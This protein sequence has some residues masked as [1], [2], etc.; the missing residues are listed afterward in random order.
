MTADNRKCTIMK[1]VILT[2]NELQLNLFYAV[3]YGLMAQ[4][5]GKNLHIIPE[6][7]ERE[8]HWKVVRYKTKE[9]SGVAGEPVFYYQINKGA[10]Q[11]NDVRLG[12]TVSYL[13][14]EA[15]KFLCEL[16]A[17]LNKPPQTASSAQTILVKK[18]VNK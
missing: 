9:S 12:V 8:F 14:E 15:E 17:F 13:R 16:Q 5:P 7:M 4:Q 18:V 1:N 10:Y 3:S 6:V 11:M 2:H